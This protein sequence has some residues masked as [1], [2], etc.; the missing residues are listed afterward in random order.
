MVRRCIFKPTRED[1]A[2]KI[3]DITG[4]HLTQQEIEDLR[5]ATIKEI[6]ILKKV[7]DHPYVSEYCNI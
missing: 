6:E 5:E 3:I 2:V 1:F 4:D 7:S